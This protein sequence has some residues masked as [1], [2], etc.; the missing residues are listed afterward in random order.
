MRTLRFRYQTVELGNY[1]IHY[2]TLRNRNQFEDPDNL[3]H[4]LG[5]SS[6]MWPIFGV[7]WPCGHLLARLMIDF[8]VGEKRVLEVGCGVGLASLMLNERLSDI[9]ATD[10]HP[11]AERYLKHNVSLNN[12]KEIPFFR[13][14]WQNDSPSEQGLFDLI[15]GSDLLYESEHVDL[16]ASFIQRH[17]ND[18]CEVVIIDAGRGMAGKFKSRMMQNGFV[19]NSITLDAAEFPKC[20]INRFLRAVV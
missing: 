17:A 12:G 15:I 13:R 6:A 11:F 14:D 8:Q 18:A 9:T 10:N 7:M 3:A 4:D 16:L 19:H 20:K 1:D 2:R 5:I